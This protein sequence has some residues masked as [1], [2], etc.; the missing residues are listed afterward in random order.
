MKQDVKKSSIGRKFLLLIVVVLVFFTCAELIVRV[1]FPFGTFQP[2]HD[3]VLQ[4]RL[5]SNASY[6]ETNM[7]T[8]V[9]EFMIWRQL[10]DHGYNDASRPLQKTRGVAR[11]A[12]AGDSFTFGY[13]VRREQNWVWLLGRKLAPE[14][15]VL[16]YGLPRSGPEIGLARYMH[17]TKR[18]NPDIVIYAFF[19]GNDVDQSPE[20]FRVSNETA[21]DTLIPRSQEI[22]PRFI[23]WRQ[24]ISG[25]FQSYAALVLLL[26]RSPLTNRIL[27]RVG[28]FENAENRDIFSLG[29]ADEYPVK[30]AY[31]ERILKEFD[32]V[33]QADGAKFVLLLLPAKE[34]VDDV[35]YE[36]YYSAR[37]L[38]P[39]VARWRPQR[40]LMAIAERNHITAIDVSPEF[41]RRNVNNTFYYTYD[42]HFNARG[43]LLTADLIQEPLRRVILQHSRTS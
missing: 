9:K 14:V 28:L 31:I 43:H 39:G 42:G 29:S 33:A 19:V 7:N 35:L 40:D 2:V 30:L 26:Q 13:G 17:D 24:W 4:F 10:N 1:F 22:P 3:A 25:R 41:V 8:F 16:N 6:L 23:R 37:N 32:R 36:K 18:F 5:P 11:V 27:Q 34:Q 21:N 20:L 15:E 12:I 38:T